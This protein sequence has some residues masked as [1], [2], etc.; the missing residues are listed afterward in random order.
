LDELRP[1]CEEEKLNYRSIREG[2]V[3][4][5]VDN[6]QEYSVLEWRNHT[7]K[8]KLLHTDISR[9]LRHLT[10]DKPRVNPETPTD[11]LTTKEKWFLDLADVTVAL[12]DLHRKIPKLTEDQ[13]PSTQTS[14]LLIENINPKTTQIDIENIFGK[15]GKVD[16]VRVSGS[17]ESAILTFA[18]QIS[19]S[20]AMRASNDLKLNGAQLAVK[21]LSALSAQKF[22]EALASNSVPITRATFMTRAFMLVRQPPFL[23][24]KDERKLLDPYFNPYLASQSFKDPSPTP[25]ASAIQSK[26]TADVWAR[27]HLE[28]NEASALTAAWTEALHHSLLEALRGDTDDASLWGC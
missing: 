11:P 3:E 13:T 14:Q 25:F 1:D 22:L 6:K 19:V 27:P 9:R 12:E 28:T 2:Y 8:R 7:K 4:L 15:Y 21:P 5:P 18:R 16:T 23:S 20:N 10:E 26:G 17:G 24:L